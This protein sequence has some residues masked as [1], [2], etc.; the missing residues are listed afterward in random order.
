MT[1]T[2]PRLSFQEGDYIGGRLREIPESR[3]RDPAAAIYYM[4]SGA[5]G[6]KSLIDNAKP[7]RHIFCFVWSRKEGATVLYYALVF[8]VVGLIAG[9][10]GAAGV[11]VASQIAWVLFIVGMILLVIH[12]ATGRGGPVV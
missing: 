1:I 5:A 11:A 7:K 9:I 8:L 10:L 4:T 12:L 6:S 3:G 2:E